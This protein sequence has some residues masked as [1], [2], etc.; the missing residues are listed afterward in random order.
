M[1]IKKISSLTESECRRLLTENYTCC[2]AFKG[3]THPF[4][5]PLLYSFDGLHLFFLATRYGRK[6]ELFYADPHVMVEVEEKS[7]DL[8]VF[9]LVTLAGCLTEVKDPHEN[10]VVRNRFVRLFTEKNISHNFLVALGHSPED[11]P[12]ILEQSERILVWKLIDIVEMRG[13]GRER[14]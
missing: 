9:N 6:I 10:Q 7:R 12:Q 5:A 1:E 2:L 13:L 11:T 3:D 14:T 4:V 8:S